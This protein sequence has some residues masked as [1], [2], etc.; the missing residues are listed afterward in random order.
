MPQ[1][2]DPPSLATFS[3]GNLHIDFVE[4]WVIYDAR[5]A[6]LRNQVELLPAEAAVLSVLIEH[7]NEALSG[8]Q[9]NE[10]VWGSTGDEAVKRTIHVVGRL[11]SKLGRMDLP[12]CP[13]EVSPFVGYRYRMLNP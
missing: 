7:R 2:G 11:Q 5:P 3:D 4:R 10:L 1:P 12:G 13:V 9:L 6:G 8:P